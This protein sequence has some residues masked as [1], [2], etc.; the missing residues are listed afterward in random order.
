MLG[1]L[2]LLATIRKVEDLPPFPANEIKSVI[3][4]A[5]EHEVVVLH[6]VDERKR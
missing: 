6:S 3:V 1:C 4:L 2:Q 5:G